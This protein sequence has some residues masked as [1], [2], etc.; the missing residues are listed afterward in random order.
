MSAT[1]PSYKKNWTKPKSDQALVWSEEMMMNPD[2]SQISN[3]GAGG[4]CN[5]IQSSYIIR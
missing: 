3:Y 1:E 5:A 4:Q 2:L